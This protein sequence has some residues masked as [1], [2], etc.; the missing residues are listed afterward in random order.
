MRTPD[1]PKEPRSQNTEE[2]KKFVDFK[3]PKH[4]F[5][6]QYCQTPKCKVRKCGKLVSVQ[7]KN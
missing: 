4:L 6:A 3:T 2:K 1:I 7:A 5:E